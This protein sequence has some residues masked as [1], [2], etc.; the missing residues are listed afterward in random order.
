MKLDKLRLVKSELDAEFTTESISTAVYYQLES[1]WLK[2]DDANTV[3]PGV[4]TALERSK[5][6]VIA[7]HPSASRTAWFHCPELMCSLELTFSKSPQLEKQKRFR[8]RI[9][10]IVERASNAYRVLHNPLTLL[11]A[12]EEFRRRLQLILSQAS[13]PTDAGTTEEIE[14]INQTAVLALDI[15][16]FKQVNDTY[17][18][19]YGDQV[20]KSFALR[21]EQVAK[22]IELAPS[23]NLKVCVAHPSGEEFLIF[24]HGSLTEQLVE[25]CAEL[26]RSK[27]AEDALPSEKE[28]QWLSQRE[29]LSML[30]PPPLRERSVTAS[31]GISMHGSIGSETSQDQVE[32]LL[33]R[34]DTA[35]YR[36]KASGRNQAVLFTSILSSCGRVLEQDLQTGIVAIDLGKNVG[37]T[38]GQEFKVFSPNFTGTKKFSVSDGRTTRTIGIYPRIELTR[39]TVFD[40]QPEISFA[41]IAN[42]DDRNRTIEQGSHLEEIP[43]GS[44]GHLLPHTSK[45]FPTK[46]GS[47]LIEGVEPLQGFVNQ[48]ADDGGSPFAVVFR[49]NAE[50]EYL[51]KYGS[52]AL[53]SAIA[54][55]FRGVTSTF[56]AAAKTGMLDR[57]TVCLVGR[58]QTYDEETLESFTDRIAEQLPELGFKVGV[59]SKKDIETTIDNRKN[60]FPVKNAIEFARF[61]ASEFAGTNS[62]R[63]THFGIESAERLVSVLRESKSFATAKADFDRLTELGVASAKLSNFGGLIHSA[64]DNH[65]RARDL[66]ED[67][68]K[69]NPKVLIYKSNF[70]TGAYSAGDVEK[71]LSIL[72]AVSDQDISKLKNIH[73]YGYVTYA[74]LLAKAKFAGSQEYNAKRFLAIGP[75]ALKVAGFENSKAS[76]VITTALSN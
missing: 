46:A 48:N 50:Q 40:V 21:L 53:N 2:L 15:D 5:G 12:R 13:K 44:I 39:L 8:G 59:F 17:G 23:N 14:Q 11:V 9:G 25:D 42:P 64:L 35:L 6:Q 26:F 16:H 4:Q 72:N 61:A 37:V 22:E 71:P 18:H 29:N 60:T 66:Y 24:L 76:A 7:Y 32:L 33:E 58:D 47:T 67:A 3:I 19:L 57:A 31:I 34:A 62:S 41:F 54:V 28:W 30:S 38:M 63:V 65:P 69:R 74:R 20:L 45:Y 52:A 75:D 36:A 51:K 27:I 49:L 68:M 10:S 1:K 73:P 55:L 43:T 56:P 70:G